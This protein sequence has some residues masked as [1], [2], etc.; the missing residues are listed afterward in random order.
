MSF[1]DLV[2]ADLLKRLVEIGANGIKMPHSPFITIYPSKNKTLLL[3]KKY[4]PDDGEMGM[5]SQYYEDTQKNTQL[6]R[7]ARDNIEQ[8]GY[9]GTSYQ[10]NHASLK[11]HITLNNIALID[12]EVIIGLI[13]LLV[14]ENAAEANNLKLEFKLI[15]PA[16]CSKRRFSMTDQF[17][18]YFHKYSSIGDIMRLSEKINTYLLGQGIQINTKALGD[19][20]IISL[21]SFVSARFDSNKLLGEYNTY[22]FFDQE[23]K[24]IF[25][26][27]KANELQLIPL[28]ALE[29]IFN[30]VISSSKITI[31]H[32]DQ[33]NN[34]LGKTES[35]YVQNEFKTLLADPLKYLQDPGLDFPSPV[36]KVNGSQN[37][38]TNSHKHVRFY[39][40]QSPK[41]PETTFDDILAFLNGQS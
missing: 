29:M 2:I 27:F 15:A 16:D 1:K 9:D 7:K 40:P 23:L 21:N 3:Q 30:K 19:K 36:S 33:N 41:S 32:A 26:T 6:K 18:I 37:N 10:H 28:C 14:T 25:E 39:K 35:E 24:I 13:K 12:T 8:S 31:P 4:K 22:P 11:M 38:N 5:Y 17:T 20:D 34:T